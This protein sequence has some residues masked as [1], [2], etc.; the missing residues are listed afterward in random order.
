MNVLNIV[1]KTQDFLRASFPQQQQIVF[2]V[3]CQKI[4]SKAPNRLWMSIMLDGSQY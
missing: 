2:P 4:Q 3:M 1:E